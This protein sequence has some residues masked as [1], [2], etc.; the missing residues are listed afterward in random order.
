LDITSPFSHLPSHVS[1]HIIRI[2]NELSSQLNS[3]LPISG[4]LPLINGVRNAELCCI[5]KGPMVLLQSLHTI[6]VAIEL[7]SLFQRTAQPSCTC[8]SI[9]KQQYY[10]V[11]DQSPT[12]RYKRY[13][14]FSN[15]Y[16]KISVKDHHE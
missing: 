4:N 13:P 9:I 11:I 16:D 7:M 14:Q 2:I 5:Y 8:Y 3:Q 1:S 12:F 10:G 15:Q 6:V